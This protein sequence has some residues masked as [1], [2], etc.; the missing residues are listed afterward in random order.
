MPYTLQAI[1]GRFDIMGGREPAGTSTIRL[2]QGFALWP[3]NSTLQERYQIPFLPLVDL[4]EEEIPIKILE[5]AAKLEQ[6][7]YVEAEYFGGEGSQV[8]V[9][10]P[11]AKSLIVP[12]EIMLSMTCLRN[13]A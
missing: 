7:A 2:S 13:L 6:C 9:F 3:I 12:L 10:F 8:A 1:I 5:F 11:K 4:G